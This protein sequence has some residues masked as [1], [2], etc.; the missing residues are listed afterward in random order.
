LVRGGEREI[1][2]VRAIRKEGGGGY[3]AP[4]WKKKKKNKLHKMEKKNRLEQKNIV[5]NP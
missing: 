2:L 4:V 3:A 1:S 5:R